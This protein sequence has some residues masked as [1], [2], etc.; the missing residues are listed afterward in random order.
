MYIVQHRNKKCFTIKF[1]LIK[2]DQTYFTHLKHGYPEWTCV[3]TGLL[4]DLFS[5]LKT[6]EKMNVNIKY[7]KWHFFNILH[8]KRNDKMISNKTSRQTSDRGARF[9]YQTHRSGDGNTP[10]ISSPWWYIGVCVILWQIARLCKSMV[11]FLYK[12]SFFLILFVYSIQGQL[13]F[14]QYIQSVK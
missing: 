5:H 14:K 7:Y 12:S 8:F 2:I 4:I 9:L 3:K 11:S 10:V 6:L 13:S 1:Q